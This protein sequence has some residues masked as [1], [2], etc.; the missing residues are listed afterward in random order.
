MIH[1]KSFRLV[2]GL[3]L[4][5]LVGIGALTNGC[6]A[7]NNAENASKGCDGLS[8]GSEADVSVKAWV[9]A[10]NALNTA[11]TGVQAQ[12]L[13]VCNDING[14]LAL[15]TSKTNADDACNVLKAY[16]DAEKANL[17][18][19][20]TVSPPQCQADISVQANCDAEC[21]AAANCDVT[22]SCTGGE[23]VVACNGS[24]SAECDVTD[25]T[26]MC[27]GTCMG[28]CSASAAVSCTG[29]CTGSCDAPTWTGTCDAGCTASF[30]GSCGGNCTGMCD[31]AT[32][33]GTVCK[34]MCVGTCSAKA[35]GS[36]SAQCTGKF[37]GGTCSGM[38]TG[39]CNVQ[40]GAMCSGTC[41]GSCAVTPGSAS[42]NGTCHGTCTGTASPPTC[43]G[44]LNCNVNAKC[45]ADCQAQAN[46]SLH[47]S[48]PTLTVAVTGDDLLLASFNARQEELAAALQA[49]TQLATPIMD[50]A[51]QTA[52]VF[53]DVSA[54][55]VACIASQATLVT[56]VSV[57]IKVSVSASATVN[58]QS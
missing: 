15:D 50:V 19:T 5:G 24:C 7:V 25:P 20:L 31:S 43:T 22:A 57:N 18:I 36:C 46:A 34:G 32:A 30:S 39:S 49:T 17:S 9:G 11:A 58:G 1:P 6:S 13:Q 42:C 3:F 23:V 44:T 38:C 54:A 27:N 2:P 35:T 4:A 40:A 53:G 37:S 8:S 21:A 26:V 52:T 55:G 56:S 10:L 14:D 29:E 51:G 33:S 12:W 16:I 45:H 47:C 41:K 28:E 48:Q